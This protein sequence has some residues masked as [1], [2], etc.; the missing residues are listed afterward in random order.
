MFR[1][2]RLL[3]QALY[4]L[5]KLALYK[6]LSEDFVSGTPAKPLRLENDLSSGTVT[7]CSHVASLIVKQAPV[8]RLLSTSSCCSTVTSRPDTNCGHCASVE[9]VHRALLIN[10]LT[11]SLLPF[12]PG[13]HRFSENALPFLP[14][15]EFEQRRVGRSH[16][17]I[18]AERTSITLNDIDY[19]C[20]VA[21]TGEFDGW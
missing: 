7:L 20:A 14:E 10:P 16:C 3:T 4:N 5:W 17:T 11:H 6:P 21:H 15:A 8:S 13:S 12:L 1:S 9:L 2:L 19:Y 18:T